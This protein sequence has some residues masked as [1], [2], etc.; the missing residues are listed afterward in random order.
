[1]DHVTDF[2]W[3]HEM[4]GVNRG[5]YHDASSMTSGRDGR[6]N[7][8]PRHDF[9]AEN[10]SQSIRVGRVYDF[11]HGHGGLTGRLSSRCFHMTRSSHIPLRK[12]RWRFKAKPDKPIS[13]F[14]TIP[15][16]PVFLQEGS[17]DR[18]DLLRS[19]EPR[20]SSRWRPEGRGD[21]LVLDRLSHCLRSTPVTT[22]VDA[23]NVYH[24]FASGVRDD[25]HLELT[26]AGGSPSRDWILWI[27]DI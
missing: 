20:L 2:H 1:M 13:C 26:E 18:A 17:P 5:R 15:V 14:R 25:R 24:D 22:L 19:R 3:G 21:H 8:D 11:C 12:R 9:S 27:G 6:C 4:Q 10:R 7:V 23:V 16:T